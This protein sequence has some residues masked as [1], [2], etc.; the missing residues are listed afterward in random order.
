[1]KTLFFETL[2][3]VFVIGTLAGYLAYIWRNSR[4]SMLLNYYVIMNL[5]AIL[6]LMSSF[7][8]NIAPYESMKWV[9]IVIEWVLRICF[10]ISFFCFGCHFFKGKHKPFIYKFFSI[11]ITLVVFTLN[12]LYSIKMM[13]S[14]IDTTPIL[15][16]IIFT[17]FFLGAYRFGLFNT[18]SIGI[19][20][21]F[22]MFEEAVLVFDEKGECL[23][24]NRACSVFDECLVESVTA[25]CRNSLIDLIKVKNDMQKKE[26]KLSEYNKI[27]SISQKAIKPVF[28]K[29]AGYICIIH[30]DTIIVTAINEL[31]EKNNLLEQMNESIKL[32]SMDVRRLAKIEERNSLA[33]D[34]HDILGHSL[35]YTL[36][37]LESNKGFLDEEPE[38]AILR[39]KQALNNIDMELSEITSVSLGKR[40]QPVNS[41][42]YI[43]AELEKMAVRLRDVGTVLEVICADNISSHNKSI[44]KILYR[45]CQ[46][47]VTNSIKHGGANHIVISF[48]KNR[49]SA[50]LHIVD[51]GQGCQEI[52][53]GSGLSGIE[54]RV[55]K[56]GGS[57]TF[58]SFEDHAGFLLYAH[59]PLD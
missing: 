32:F 48:S 4:R 18:L 17:V 55:H 5:F 3:A 11:F 38:K 2:L 19:I 45:I 56:V 34:I 54:D 15:M 33:K 51:N 13:Y 40:K 23:Y 59:I 7:F 47:A 46:E 14:P 31:N 1:M 21:S 43:V 28:K 16:L 37:V 58:K 12:F 24:R 42:S 41:F 30:D 53:K 20:R 27:L 29:M 26:M 25:L 39:L 35:N 57:V 50:I 6:L 8:D 22:E 52:V 36:K 49:N 10:I 9:F 44:F